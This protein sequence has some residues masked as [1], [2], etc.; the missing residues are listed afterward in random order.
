MN[1]YILL[2]LSLIITLVLECS[3]D[4]IYEPLEISYQ[5]KTDINNKTVLNDEI[6]YKDIIG[7]D[8]SNYT[9]LIDSNAISRIRKYYFGPDGLPFSLKLLGETIYSGIFLPSYSDLGPYGI[10]IDPEQSLIGNKLTVKIYYGFCRTDNTLADQ[11]NDRRIIEVLQ[12]DHK[13]MKI[14]I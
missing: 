14:G 10:I 7:Y 3:K 11:R 8:T 9:F 13:L 5:A 4:K 1:K 12:N 2:V 6:S